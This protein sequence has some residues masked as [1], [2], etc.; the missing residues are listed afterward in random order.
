M[1]GGDIHCHFANRILKD[2]ADPKSRPVA[3]EFVS[4]AISSF[5]RDFS[6]LMLPGAGN[7]TTIV[8]IHGQD[9][10]YVMCD[11]SKDEFRVSMVGV[12]AKSDKIGDKPVAEHRYLVR[13]GSHE[14]VKV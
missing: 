11:V 3:P 7:E 12:D 6:P 1:L 10:G 9:H 8:G 5:L 2:W 4:T 13:A 14:P